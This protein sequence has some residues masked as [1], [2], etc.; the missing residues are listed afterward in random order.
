MEV[1]TA[2]ELEVARSRPARPIVGV[3]SR[4]LDTFRIDTEAAWQIVR[5][6]PADRIAVAESGMA[7]RR[8]TSRAPRRL[9]RMRF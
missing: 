6:V 4:D 7:E 1:H 2:D 8:R 9:E 5:A 3:N